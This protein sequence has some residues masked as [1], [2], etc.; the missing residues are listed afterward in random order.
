MANSQPSYTWQKR[1]RVKPI[2]G[3]EIGSNCCFSYWVIRRV[4][5]C[6]RESEIPSLKNTQPLRQHTL[7]RTNCKKTVKK[8]LKYRSLS[9]PQKLPRQFPRLTQG[10][11]IGSMRIISFQG[12]LLSNDYEAFTVLYQHFWGRLDYQQ[13]WFQVS[14]IFIHTPHSILL[15][16]EP[17]LRSILGLG[18]RHLW[19]D[20]GILSTRLA[21]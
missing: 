6:W 20:P 1:H 15:S 3:E 19:L 17:P 11:I 21:R 5:I 2:P 13:I 8:P 14:N 12:W 16:I 10:A 7:S 4:V 9:R 18:W